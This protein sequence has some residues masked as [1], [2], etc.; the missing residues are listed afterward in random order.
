MND[1]VTQAP[2]EQAADSE[3]EAALTPA[4]IEEP[5]SAIESTITEEL[6]IIQEEHVAEPVAEEGAESPVR[7]SPVGK[8]RV[9]KSPVPEPLATELVTEP[10][11]AGDPQFET[12]V[13]VVEAEIMPPDAPNAFAPETD[14]QDF[15]R[16][17]CIVRRWM[18]D[19][20]SAGKAL[21]EIN[22]RELWRPG[23]HASWAAYSTNVCGMSKTQANRLIAAAEVI[24]DLKQ[25]TPTGVT[26]LLLPRNE[27]PVRPL[28]RLKGRE[29]RATAWH[30]AVERAG[31]QPTSK[32]IQDVVAALMAE[33][34][35]EA[36]N[37]PNRKQRI[38]D[39]YHQLDAA[40]TSGLALEEIGNRL[41]KLG[42]LIKLPRRAA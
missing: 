25:V 8:S 39:A 7:K 30:R 16:L 21:S 24:E 23:G 10:Q 33:E 6:A 1:S 35:P 26:P 2:S 38:A 36:N 29:K 3:T 37:K 20:P 13:I 27:S 4:Q 34:N 42:E 15:V 18:K 9:P 12:G 32:I 31:S 40:V 28:C 11:A 17:D 41:K 22:R 19:F 5:V 14:H